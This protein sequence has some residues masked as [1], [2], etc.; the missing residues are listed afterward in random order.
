[1]PHFKATVY[2]PTVSTTALVATKGSISGTFT[3]GSVAVNNALIGSGEK[4]FLTALSNL[5]SGITNLTCTGLTTIQGAI[6]TIKSATAP[7]PLVATWTVGS[8]ANKVSLYFWKATATN[9]TT[10]TVNDATVSAS[11]LVFGS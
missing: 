11:L 4:I 9:D 10:L 1:M 6:V 3:V 5:T 2:S 7:I 8:A